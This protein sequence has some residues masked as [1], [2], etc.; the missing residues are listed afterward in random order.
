[1]GFASCRGCGRRCRV[2][3]VVAVS[4]LVCCFVLLAMLPFVGMRVGW[5]DTRAYPRLFALSIFSRTKMSK[6]GKIVTPRFY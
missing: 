2:F 6:W 5:S 1:M 4:V 3:V